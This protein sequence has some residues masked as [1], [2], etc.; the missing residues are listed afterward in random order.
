MDSFTRKVSRLKIGIDLKQQPPGFVPSYT[1][2]D[3][4]EGEVT[5]EADRDTNFDHI[6]ITFEGI[7]FF[8]PTSRYMLKER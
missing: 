5:I 6:A 2:L 3:R 4:I 7:A 1:T 8:S